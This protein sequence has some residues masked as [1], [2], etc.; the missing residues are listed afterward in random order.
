[1][2][3]STHAQSCLF[4]DPMGCSPPGSSVHGILQV[5][6]LKSVVISSCRDF[7]KVY[8]NVADK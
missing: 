7:F 4:W 6:T 2:N 5:K 8:K 3:V 1:M